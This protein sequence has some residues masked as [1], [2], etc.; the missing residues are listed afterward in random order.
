MSWLWR[1]CSPVSLLALLAL[2]VFGG[3]FTFELYFHFASA[4]WQGV[5]AVVERID[6]SPKSATLSYRYRFDG[7]DYDG[8]RFQYLSSGSI[9]EKSEIHRFRPGDSLVVLVDP[10][11]PSRSVVQRPA[12]KAGHVMPWLLIIGISAAALVYSLRREWRRAER[13]M[14]G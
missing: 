12:L 10:A 2:G 6:D 14:E 13:E 1:F 5:P 3:R 7:Q 8:H 11:K 9:D 4:S